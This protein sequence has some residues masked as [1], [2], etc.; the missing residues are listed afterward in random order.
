[1]HKTSVNFLTFTI[2]PVFFSLINGSLDLRV[3]YLVHTSSF[4]FVFL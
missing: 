3:N 4:E 2:K 1:M